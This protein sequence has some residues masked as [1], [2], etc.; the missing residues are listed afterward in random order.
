MVPAA[1]NSCFCWNLTS[2]SDLSLSAP[3]GQRRGALLGLGVEPTSAADTGFPTLVLKLC[4]QE[5]SPVTRP[6]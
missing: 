2:W 6:A 5:D 3:T 1:M 4:W